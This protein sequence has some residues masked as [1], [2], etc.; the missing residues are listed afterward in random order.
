MDPDDKLDVFEVDAIWL[1]E[2]ALKLD[3]IMSDPNITKQQLLFNLK[4]GEELLLRAAGSLKAVS[5][6]VADCPET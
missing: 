5:K 6:F 3:A 2:E 1:R 4:R